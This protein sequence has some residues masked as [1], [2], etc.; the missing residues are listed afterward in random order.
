MGGALTGGHR[1]VRVGGVAARGTYIGPADESG[2][3]QINAI[4]AESDA[5]GLVP[6]ELLWFDQ[7]LCDAAVLRVIPAGPQ[8]PRI[9]SVADGVNLLSGTRIETGSVKVTLEEVVAIE[10]FSASIDG[11][12]I[13][14]VDTFRTDP[15]P[16]R[17]EVNFR[18]PEGLA[19]GTH[20][21]DIRLGRRRFAPVVI[22][23]A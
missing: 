6:V 4:L 10:E 7:S 1:S 22:E 5:T 8:V 11:V 23:I 17:W 12:K 20:L 2:V 16:R 15:L 18:V 21:L 19:A 13:D 9:M 14:G 3:Q